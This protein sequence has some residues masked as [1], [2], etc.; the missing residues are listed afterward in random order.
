MSIQHDNELASR[1]GGRTYRYLI[2]ETVTAW[3]A[4]IR[5][6]EMQR[7]AARLKIVDAGISGL[8]YRPHRRT[9]PPAP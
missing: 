6:E 8:Q 1:F 4:R 7:L 2:P 3:A 5:A 9:L